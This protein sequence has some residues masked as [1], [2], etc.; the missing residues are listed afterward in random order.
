MVHPQL[1]SLMLTCIDSWCCSVPG[2]EFASVCVE[3]HEVQVGLVLQLAEDHVNS[4][5]ALHCRN[6][7]VPQGGADHRLAEDVFCP[8]AVIVD[9]DI[10]TALPKY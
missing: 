4:S 2:A 6:F 5:P 7:S 3:L 9:E 10:L 1:V 8:F